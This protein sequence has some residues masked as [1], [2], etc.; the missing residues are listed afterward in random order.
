[1][2]QAFKRQFVT[3]RALLTEIKP[4]TQAAAWGGR[5]GRKL[6]EQQQEER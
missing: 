6:E 2:H 1:M 4:D 5:K 3:Y